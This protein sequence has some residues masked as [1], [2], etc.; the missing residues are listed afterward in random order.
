MRFF[1]ARFIE[2]L[3]WSR[4][5]KMIFV[6]EKDLKSNG[7]IE[8][9]CTNVSYIS[10][11]ERKMQ[12]WDRFRESIRRVKNLFP[13]IETPL[14]PWMV[15]SKLIQD[16]QDKAFREE[17]AQEIREIVPLFMS[18][19]VDELR[20]IDEDA[21]DTYI[22]V[23]K[24]A[25]ENDSLERN[26][27]IAVKYIIRTLNRT[28]ENIEIKVEVDRDQ[29]IDEVKILVQK[30][31]NTF[32][33]KCGNISTRVECRDQIVKTVFS[34]YRAYPLLPALFAL[35]AIKQCFSE[36]KEAKKNLI[37]PVSTLPE[38]QQNMKQINY[39]CD[40]ELQLIK[41]VRV[42]LSQ[43]LEVIYR[44]I[45][46]CKVH[47][48]SQLRPFPYNNVYW[49][50]EMGREKTLQKKQEQKWKRCKE[51][52][53]LICK[54]DVL[55]TDMALYCGLSYEKMIQLRGNLP[56]YLILQDESNAKLVDEYGEQA[57]EIINVFKELSRAEVYSS[58]GKWNEILFNVISKNAKNAKPFF[59]TG[60]SQEEYAYKLMKKYFYNVNFSKRIMAQAS[61]NL[62]L[63]GS[64]G[65]F[66]KYYS[67][68]IL[69]WNMNAECELYDED[70][71]NKHLGISTKIMDDTTASSVPRFLK[72]QIN[73]ALTTK[74][75][76]K[77]IED[78][79]R[80]HK[81]TNIKALEKY[82]RGFLKTLQIDD[83]GNVNYYLRQVEGATLFLYQFL[84]QQACKILGHYSAILLLRCNALWHDPNRKDDVQIC[85]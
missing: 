37:R 77:L 7:K 14:K 2:N 53:I 6:N 42:A 65:M 13:D 18:F 80:L 45:S 4:K 73:E 46:V 27:S 26:E 63:C 43:A 61:P 34:D 9:S 38:L 8:K 54:T 15:L 41:E 36:R 32:A 48:K 10:R 11:K 55:A 28:A 66:P 81:H 29:I 75:A 85:N 79:E 22:K 72:R 69:D 50:D 78:H 74:Q 62:P 57:F 33:N 39:L 25:R 47:S 59:A 12:Y 51:F 49:D 44:P 64:K 67:D 83:T 31:Y 30:S 40:Q 84:L 68:L 16:A 58:G 1:S 24:K 71:L 19:S 82:V 17:H 56:K 23:L 21:V 20:K 60:S 70:A 76:I 52:G 35:D 5:R 3:T